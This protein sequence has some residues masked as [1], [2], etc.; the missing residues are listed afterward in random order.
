MRCLGC[1]EGQACQGGDCDD[2][3]LRRGDLRR[4]RGVAGTIA[5]W[6]ERLDIAAGCVKDARRLMRA[7]DFDGADDAIRACA[8]VVDA[9]PR[10]APRRGT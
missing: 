1:A 3:L 6:K 8:E 2:L 9:A 4:A 10:L 5:E 7:G